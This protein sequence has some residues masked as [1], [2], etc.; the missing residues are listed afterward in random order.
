MDLYWGSCCYV[1][2]TIFVSLGV[3]MKYSNLSLGFYFLANT[4]AA[5]LMTYCFQYRS[6]WDVVQYFAFASF[7]YVVVGVLDKVW[8]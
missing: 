8:K 4:V 6:P 2:T 5:A 3:S 7:F 1:C